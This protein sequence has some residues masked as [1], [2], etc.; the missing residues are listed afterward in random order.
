[1]SDL[2]RSTNEACTRQR[3]A[4]LTA[5]PDE[6]RGIGDSELARHIR[7]CGRCASDAQR[8]LGTTAMLAARLDSSARISK[9]RA[10]AKS[11]AL[12]VW[13]ALP[14][15]AVLA[16]VLIGGQRW[17]DR[18]LEV[19]PRVGTLQRMELPVDVPV[20]NVPADRN[21]AVFRTTENVTV[22]WDLGAKGGS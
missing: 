12:P 4:L 6:L 19:V 10:A 21:V 7:E 8:I 16:S 14:I 11:D 3:T 22:V 2:E 18:D 5:D 17:R 15:A 9:N 13:W 20:V 1:M